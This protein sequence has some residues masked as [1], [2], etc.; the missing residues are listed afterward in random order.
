MGIDD[1]STLQAGVFV[2]TFRSPLANIGPSEETIAVRS[3][4]RMRKLGLRLVYR[5]VEDFLIKLGGYPAQLKLG[6]GAWFLCDSTN[7]SG[8]TSRNENFYIDHAE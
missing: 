1:I 6:G 8:V 2:V 7:L 4:L 3:H 5:C